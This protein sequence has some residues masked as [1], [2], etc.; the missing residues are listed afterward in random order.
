LNNRLIGRHQTKT[1]HTG[2]CNDGP[3]GGI[4]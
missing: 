4:P 1:V 2:R 3:V